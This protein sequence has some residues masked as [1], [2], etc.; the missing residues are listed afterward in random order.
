MEEFL[1][2]LL[3]WPGCRAPKGFGWVEEGI[4]EARAQIGQRIADLEQRRGSATRALILPL[5]AKRPTATNTKRPFRACVVQ[6]VIPAADDFP[7]TDLVLNESAF[8][9]DIAITCPRRWQR[10]NAC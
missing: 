2:A 3:R 10:W 1:L 6:T 9:E 8:G 5:L 7:H 4:E